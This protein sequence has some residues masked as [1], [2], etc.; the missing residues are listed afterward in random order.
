MITDILFDETGEDLLFVNGD[1]VIGKSTEQHINH[2]LKA[3]KADFRFA[4]QLGAGVG[5][6][7]LDEVDEQEVKRLVRSELQRDGMTVESVT[8]ENG[9][10]KVI[11]NY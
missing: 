2:I 11:A 9:V 7:L 8:I 6:L 3:Y 1:L 4:P 10:L 5:T